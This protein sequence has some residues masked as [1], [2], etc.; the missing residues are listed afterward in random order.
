[1][2]TDI[3]ILAEV[4]DPMKRRWVPAREPVKAR[5]GD[6]GE[7]E[8]PQEYDGRNYNL[9]AILADVRNGRGFAGVQIGEGF[10][11][12]SEPRG[13]P[14]DLCDEYAATARREDS[15]E[16]ETVA[17]AAPRADLGDHSQTWLSL[18]ELLAFDW[19]QR[20]KCC[21]W[22]PWPVFVRW[23]AKVG[24]ET[25]PVDIE[26]ETYS[27]GVS[28]PNIRHLTSDEALARYKALTPDQRYAFFREKP[29][30]FSTGDYVQV[31]WIVT[32]AAEASRFWAKA[33]LPLLSLANK[34]GLRHDQARFV[35]GF[36]S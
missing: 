24:D 20:S 14:A 34:R 5:W 23:M 7:T 11:P 17:T 36:D 35:M 28:G 21:G 3:H 2:G 27:G 13:L 12:I 16:D 31:W 30:A 10:N 29:D 33:V 6:E 22:V 19:T 8:Y 26:P 18:A 4:F 32:Y 15:D 9:F 1:M 25:D